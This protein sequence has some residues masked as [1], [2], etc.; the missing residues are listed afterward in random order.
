MN[1][2]IVGMIAFLCTFGG[3][4]LGMLLRSVLREHHLTD[5]SEGSVKVAIG[6]IA[7]MTAL[8][9]GLITASAKSSFDSVNTAVKQSATQVLA[10]D[11][12]LARYGPETAEIRTA[13]KQ[14]LGTRID[15]IWPQGSIR[16]VN[17][18]PMSSGALWAG[19]KLAEGIRNLKPHNES[20]QALK[21]RALDL[22]ETVMQT[23]WFVLAGSENSVPLPFLVVLLFWLTVIFMSFGVFSEPNTIVIA[24]LF[25]CALSIGAALFL[26]LELDKPFDGVLRVSADPMR[27]AYKHLNQ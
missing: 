11:R 5:R 1:S 13:L 15:M 17:L 18:D 9:L 19:E 4:L 7:M 10:L 6:L 14:M 26:V 24:A 23:R 20:Q 12:A 16:P 27:Y 2:F 3:V 25:V 22:T 8:V 21:S